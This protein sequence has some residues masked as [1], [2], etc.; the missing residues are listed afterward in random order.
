MGYTE[1]NPP[2]ILKFYNTFPGLRI[3]FGSS[4]CFKVRITSSA[5]LSFTRGS[6]SRLAM[7]M[8]CSAEIEPCPRK[9][10]ELPLVP[11]S[12]HPCPPS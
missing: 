8:P 6:Q 5:T 3:P 12:G 7:P 11:L 10:C 2:R 4:V 9:C 1:R